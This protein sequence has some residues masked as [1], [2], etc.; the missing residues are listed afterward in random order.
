MAPINGSSF[1]GNKTQRF[2]TVAEDSPLLETELKNNFSSKD[3][4]APNTSLHRRKNVWARLL[5]FDADAVRFAARL[6]VVLLLS[7]LFDLLRSPKTHSTYPYG[8][9]VIISALFVSWFP[10]LDAAS[11]LEKIMQRWLGTVIGGILGIIC[12]VLSLTF[13]AR[14]GQAWFIGISILGVTFCV[15]SLAGIMQYGRVKIIQRFS[16]ATLLCM[17]TFI[18]C[19]MPFALGDFHP[20]DGSP[21]KWRPGIFRIINV[22]LGCLIAGVGAI[23][24]CPRSTLDVLHEKTAKQV[25]LAGEASEAVLLTASEAFSGRMQVRLLSKDLLETK[26]KGTFQLLRSESSLE[27]PSSRS[28]PIRAEVALEKYEDAISDWKASKALFPLLPF[29]PFSIVGKPIDEAYPTE[30][31]TTLSRALRIQ[32][33]VVVLDGM[34]RNE[35]ECEFS[36]ELLLLFAETGKLIR[37]MLTLPLQPVQSTEAARKLFEKLEQVRKGILGVSSLISEDATKRKPLQPILEDSIIDFKTRLLNMDTDSVRMEDDMGRGVPKYATGI[38]GNQ[39]LFLQLVEHLIVRSLRLYH[40]W[41]KVDF[42]AT[43]TP[44][45]K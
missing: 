21:P 34:V 19:L 16:Y 33:T 41:K 8:T 35:S 31:A 25:K 36:D 24:V 43:E 39:M 37:Q 38:D 9:W 27:T 14:P 45:V 18:I 4:K 42:I 1:N 2:A 28:K 15:V 32:A 12:G 20:A 26:H 7:A 13:P 6:A 30:M 3:V 5:R 22:T 10:S 17:S 29:D 23:I 11:V 40:A 44:K